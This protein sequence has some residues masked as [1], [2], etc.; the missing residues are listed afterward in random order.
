M[1]HLFNG[2]AI[3]RTVFLVHEI[4]CHRKSTRSVVLLVTQTAILE[5]ARSPKDHLLA[6]PSNVLPA[7]LDK[8]RLL[9]VT[10]NDESATVAL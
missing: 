9:K 4:A 6:K 1:A 3:G 2:L 10:L 5:T 7:D 8:T